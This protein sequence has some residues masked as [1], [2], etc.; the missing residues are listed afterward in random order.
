MKLQVTLQQQGNQA[1]LDEI[2]LQSEARQGEL[3]A[4]AERL[5]AQL[6]ASRQASEAE[7]ARLGALAAAQERMEEAKQMST[8]VAAQ[9]APSGYAWIDGVV[10]MVRPGITLLFVLLYIAVKALMVWYVLRTAPSNTDP[11]TIAK[12]LNQVWRDEDAAAF[13]GILAFWFGGRV[14]E[15]MRGSARR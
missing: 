13:T 6:E 11:D 9:E 7:I 1:R 2:R 5:K 3:A 4:E 12:V 14:F 8:R 10:R 15:K